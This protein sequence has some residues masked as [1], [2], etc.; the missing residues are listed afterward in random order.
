M[1]PGESFPL[2]VAPEI[3]ALVRV[4]WV[5]A[6]PVC[7]APAAEPLRRAIADTSA[8]LRAAHAGKAPGDIP[9]LQGARRLYRA[10]GVDP[11][12]TRPSSEA[13]LR[14]VLK[15]KPFPEVNN[16][17]DLI[18]LAALRFWLSLGLYDLGKL[19]PPVTLRRGRAGE[20]YEGIRKDE[21]HLDGRL[22]LADARGAF[23]NP[24]SDSLRAS[25]DERTTSLVAVIFAPADH[26]AETLARQ[27]EW[28]RA[29]MGRHLGPPACPTVA[30]GQTIV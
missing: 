28:L 27:V 3:G 19:T 12:R 2:T 9:E 24:T 15:D 18:N 5:C 20:R 6:A 1:N 23:G 16:A 17:V 25:V 11:T 8:E 29:E 22:A 30:W 7:I 21:V 13:L 26:P 14:R 4:G 10:F